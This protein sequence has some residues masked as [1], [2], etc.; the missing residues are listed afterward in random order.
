MEPIDAAILIAGFL[1]LLGIAGLVVEAHLRTPAHD[2]ARRRN[3]VSRR[4][5]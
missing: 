2:D 1:L 3:H 4:R 5:A